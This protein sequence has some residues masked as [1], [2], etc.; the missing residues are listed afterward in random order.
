[1]NHARIS[2]TKP[3]AITSGDPAGVGPEIIAKW[4]LEYPEES[5]NCCV[6][7]PVTWLQTLPRRG[8]VAFSAV[9]DED[10]L[11]IPGQPTLEGSK[12]ALESMELAA[13]GCLEN[14]YN[15]VVTGPV[16]KAWLAKAGYPFPGQ[17]EFFASRWG[18]EPVM[19]F[20][21]ERLKVILATWHVPLR[22]VSQSLSFDVLRRAIQQAVNMAA[23]A[24]LQQPHSS[25]SPRIGVCGLNP[26]AGED[27]ILGREELDHI[28]PWL[29]AMREEM[30]L[31][32][33]SL[34]QPADTLF[35]R[36]L[37]GEFDAIVALYHDQGLAPL[38]TLEFDTAVNCTLGL[39]FVRTSPDHGTAFSIAG[40]H[41]AS[42]KSFR[43]AVKVARLLIANRS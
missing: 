10:F 2:A 33:L 18:G 25:F 7:G 28:D 37:Q 19:G 9:G 22:E 14:R 27:G 32:G 31:P 5:A 24:S 29:N 6:M 35:F 12:L 36:S 34:C 13:D 20:W 8:D 15:G 30:N 39:P 1:M 43:N 26:H 4:L 42:L 3:L 38:K 11:V 21:G 17:T 40:Q 16:S 41:K 23:A